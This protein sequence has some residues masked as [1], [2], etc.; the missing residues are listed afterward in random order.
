MN[1][2][3]GNGSGY[4]TGNRGATLFRAFTALMHMSE[5]A[6]AGLRFRIENSA[7]MRRMLTRAP[8]ELPPWLWVGVPTGASTKQKAPLSNMYMTGIFPP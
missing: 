7:Q 2:I 8:H 6:L 3:C 1:M 4:L 5:F